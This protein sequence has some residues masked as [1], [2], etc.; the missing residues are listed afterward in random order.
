MP[1][2]KDL[3]KAE[4]YTRKHHRFRVLDM[5]W[6]NLPIPL[7][8]RSMKPDEWVRVGW[9]WNQRARVINNISLGWIAFVEDQTP[10]R[11]ALCPMCDRAKDE[12]QETT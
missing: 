8:S 3:V 4:E 11:L 10:E 5:K 1:T 12:Q 7:Y 9:V 2:V 6:W